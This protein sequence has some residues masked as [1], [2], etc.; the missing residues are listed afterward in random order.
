M[1]VNDL[2]QL[3][4]KAG[5]AERL[6]ETV[7]LMVRVVEQGDLKVPEGI[8]GLEVTLKCECVW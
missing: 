8:D 7:K 6:V 2:G 1:T 4:L 3:T 5:D